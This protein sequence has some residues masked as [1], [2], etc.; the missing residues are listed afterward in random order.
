MGFPPLPP[1]SALSIHFLS[2]SVSL[3]IGMMLTPVW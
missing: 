1:Y 2:A 3:L